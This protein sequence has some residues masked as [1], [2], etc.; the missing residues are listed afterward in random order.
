MSLG[1]LFR[2]GR[3]SADAGSRRKAVPRIQD[4]AELVRIACHDPDLEVRILAVD[5]LGAQTVLRRVAV[6]GEH[7]DAR[8]RAVRRIED[9]TRDRVG[10]AWGS[11]W[12]TAWSARTVERSPSSPTRAWEPSSTSSC[13]SP[14]EPQPGVTRQ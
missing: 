6:E 11:W 3:H 7:L 14:S 10:R 13:R 1:R 12:C 2:T 4:E 9:P 8:L 5:R